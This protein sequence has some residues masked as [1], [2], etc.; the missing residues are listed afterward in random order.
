MR[1]S[2]NGI[3]NTSFQ[4]FYLKLPKIYENQYNF[5][6]K[7]LQFILKVIYYLFLHSSYIQSSDFLL[8]FPVSNEHYH[9]FLFI[10][11]LAKSSISL[12]SRAK[13]SEIIYQIFK[14]LSSILFTQVSIA[15][16]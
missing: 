6:L 14:E 13:A 12:Y 1:L 5:N 7:I 4:T 3:V 15:I 8:D 2:K 16:R 11:I 9:I 10:L